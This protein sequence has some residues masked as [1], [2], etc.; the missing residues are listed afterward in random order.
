MRR[1][2]HLPICAVLGSGFLALILSSCGGGRTALIDG[3]G[4]QSGVDGGRGSQ[5]GTPVS[6][7]GSCPPPTGL[8]GSGEHARCYAL[9]IDPANCGACGHACTPGIACR[10]GVCQQTPCTGPVAFQET[11]RFP[12]RVPFAKD[13]YNRAYSATDVN[14]DGRLDFIEFDASDE[15]ISIVIWLGQGDGTFVASTSYATVGNADV[16]VLSWHVLAPDFNEDGLV[17]LA[18][19]RAKGTSIEVRPGLPGGGFGGRAGI[20]LSPSLIADLDG[21]GH[22]DAVSSP[23]SST[24]ETAS[25]AVFRGRGNGALT[26]VADYTDPNAAIA[27]FA[28]ADWDGDGIDDLLLGGLTMHIMLGKGDA[29][30]APEQN[31]GVKGGPVGDFNHDG[32]LDMAWLDQGLHRLMTMFGLGICAFAAR[33][34]YPV[35]SEPRGLGAGDLS[36]DGLVDLVVAQANSTSFFL[37]KADGTF[38]TGPDLDIDTKGQMFVV[39]V[40]GDGR[41]DLVVTR[42]DGIVVYSN[43]CTR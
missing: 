5:S 19:T 18:V 6:D 15:N 23:S 1:A 38:S 3:G 14:R 35:P 41:A 17:D 43:T 11:G 33:T 42:Y 30:F 29:T 20:P 34:D 32:K 2:H 13:L 10:G 28:I 24:S 39:D 31:C 4:R 8:C 9:D 40:T 25:F 27:P 37:G 7:D 16:P 26:K 36:G 12:G 22:L 21:D